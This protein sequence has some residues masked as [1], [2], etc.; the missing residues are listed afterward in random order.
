MAYRPALLLQFAGLVLVGTYC[1]KAHGPP[2][3][4]AAP[5]EGSIVPATPATRVYLLV[6]YDG[7]PV[8]HRLDTT[9]EGCKRTLE[10]AWYRLSA[11][12][13][14]SFDTVTTECPPG[15]KTSLLS[16]GVHS[17]GRII[18]SADTLVFLI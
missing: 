6:M 9:Y 10:G 4:A 18:H 15:K 17:S 3:P 12:H 13:Y 5:Q 2:A 14:E 8:P 1:R 11:D 16:T 7:E